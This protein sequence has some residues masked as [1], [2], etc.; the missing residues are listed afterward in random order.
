MNKFLL[1]IFCPVV[2]AFLG[3]G[4]AGYRSWSRM[5]T[6]RR[7]AGVLL[8]TPHFLIIV[9][10]VWNMLC[11]HPA[12]G[13]DCYNAQFAGAVLMVFILPLPALAGSLI[14]LAL[15]TRR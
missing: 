12:V 11:G 10:A 7:I 5:G 14:A 9:C 4:Y 13:S 8:L 2:L 1:Y 3:I 6:R 15:F